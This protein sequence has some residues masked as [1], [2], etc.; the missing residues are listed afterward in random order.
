MKSSPL[1]TINTHT[2]T[3]IFT[4]NNIKSNKKENENQANEN[5][6]YILK[7]KS[8]FELK[9]EMRHKYKS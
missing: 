9:R 8:D 1:K 6:D 4:Y 5:K 2:H 7:Y 3:Y